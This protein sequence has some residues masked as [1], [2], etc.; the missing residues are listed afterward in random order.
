MKRKRFGK[1]MVLKRPNLVYDRVSNFKLVQTQFQMKDS[2]RK[3]LLKE[4]SRE[5]RVQMKDRYNDR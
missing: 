2:L 3:E 4:V 5:M 1:E